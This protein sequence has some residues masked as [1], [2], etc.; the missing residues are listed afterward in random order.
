[1]VRLKLIPDGGDFGGAG[2]HQKIS[3]SSNE[4][5]CDDAM[6]K[7]EEEEEESKSKINT[8]VIHRK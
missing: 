2:R 4:A 7:E 5:S 8:G 6:T 3:S 1:V